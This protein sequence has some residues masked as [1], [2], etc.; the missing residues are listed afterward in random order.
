MILGLI[1]PAAT[2][3]SIIEY[4]NV[5]LARLATAELGPLASQTVQQGLLLFAFLLSV[6]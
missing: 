3:V 4:F 1:G 2:T 6:L 5:G